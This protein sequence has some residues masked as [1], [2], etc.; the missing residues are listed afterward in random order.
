VAD[1]FYLFVEDSANPAIAE[2]KGT[3]WFPVDPAYRVEAKFE[4]YDEPQQ[5]RL[6]LT[7]V[8]TTRPMEST[9]EVMFLLGGRPRRLKA[10][11]DEGELFI[12]F[13]D[14]TNG[15]ETYGGGRFLHA[16]VAKDGITVL[17]FNKAF[18]PYC[19]INPY[20]MCPVPPPG[21]RLDAPLMAG[22]KYPQ[23]GVQ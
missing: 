13:Q 1:D 8:D 14:S 23:E 17:D 7:H 4:P 20:V 12:M 2:F 22:E 10:F 9:G 5:V 19:S 11:L 16:P 21:S 3:T 6:S 18:N 15:T